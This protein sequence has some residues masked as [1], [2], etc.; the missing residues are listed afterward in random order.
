MDMYI[1]N[2]IAIDSRTVRQLDTLP[3]PCGDVTGHWYY[4]I[5]QTGNRDGWLWLV[6]NGDPVVVHEQAI[7]DGSFDEHL[8]ILLDVADEIGQL[9][10]DLGS[11]LCDCVQ[12]R[13][14]A[15]MCGGQ[16]EAD[17]ATATPAED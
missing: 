11:W 13:Q 3:V 9:D 15:L 1:S 5:A 2:E 14:N 8:Y 16:G 6:Y 17:E 10:G 12:Q 4:G 7:R